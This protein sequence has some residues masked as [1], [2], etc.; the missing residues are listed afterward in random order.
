LSELPP[1]LYPPDTRV[2]G[3]RLCFDDSTGAVEWVQRFADA[4]PGVEVCDE[5]AECI[6][7]AYSRLH[8]GKWLT[9]T[10]PPKPPS[11]VKATIPA[12]L[13]AQVFERDLYRCKHCTTHLNLTVDH[14]VPESQ[15]GPTVL[16]NLQTLCRSCNS[17]KG[18]RPA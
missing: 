3:C 7:N 4:V 14:V 18:T 12:T 10:N 9:W 15:G 6:A 17:R 11:Y 8:S 2:K 13:R 1:V 16:K 5:C